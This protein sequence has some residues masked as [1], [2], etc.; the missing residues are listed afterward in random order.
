[1]P[2]RA[3]GRPKRLD[4]DD[5][6]DAVVALG[7]DRFTMSRVAADLGVGEGTV[8]N[9]F[10]SREELWGR[11]AARILDQ[12]DTDAEGTPDW[13]D[14]LVAVNDHLRQLCIRHPGLAAYYLH[15][16]YQPRTVEYFDSVIGGV[17]ERMTG[18]DADLAFVFAS[19]AST[20]TLSFLAEA[21]DDVFAR[22]LRATLTALEQA[23]DG[24]APDG[25]SWSAVKPD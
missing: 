13:V 12:I 10:R 16:P 18:T 22:V 20:T 23:L 8:Y 5:V 7:L 3:V 6:L 17:I 2:P 15:G 21:S 9:Y 1:M 19:H 11:A 4:P 24:A 25:I 14:Y